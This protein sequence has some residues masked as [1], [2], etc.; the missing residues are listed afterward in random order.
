MVENLLRE[1]GLTEYEIRAFVTLL[2]LKTATAEQ[3]SEVGNIPLP[4][5]YDTLAELKNKGFVLIS[6]TRPKKFKSLSPE[7]ALYNLVKIKKVNF[8]EG[9]RYL[10]NNIKKVNEI[11]SK[12]EPI[13][14][15][16]SSDDIWATEKRI[17]V[18]NIFNEEE[19]KAKKEILIFAG[20]VSWL[21]ERI[22]NIKNI[23]NK[24]V[25]VRI[26][27]N[28]LGSKDIIKNIN[29]IK[30]LGAEIKTGYK[31][32]LR[33]EIIDD[34]NA[35]IAFKDVTDTTEKNYSSRYELTIF[36]NPVMIK[37]FKENFNFWWNKLKS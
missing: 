15:I 26:L 8:E 35:L 29:R 36:K 13:E 4:R 11:L 23:I 21:P 9:I 7:K 28:E 18:Q 25:K 37:V 22:N 30:K 17:N 1:F 5:V 2:K 24:G 16:E 6:K 14:I 32:S 3:I 27:M 10:E 12:I 31:S 34:N 20:D 19:E 33:G